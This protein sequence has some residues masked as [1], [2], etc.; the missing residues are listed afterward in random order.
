LVIEKLKGGIMKLSR[1]TFR[2][3][4]ACLLLGAGMI[5][6]STATRAQSGVPIAPASSTGT[7]ATP[8]W[9]TEQLITSTVH[10]AWML[11]G[12]DEATFFEM[13][14]TLAEI[15]AKNRGIALPDTKAA[16]QRMGAYIKRTAKADTDQL[17]YA[18]VDKAV[19]LTAHKG[20]TPAGSRSKKPK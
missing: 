9:T 2:T 11:S 3:T 12:K 15:S 17:L 6:V 13:V 7:P 16:G 1:G 8:T 20:P 10:D 14:K 18:V 19:M 4:A 5:M